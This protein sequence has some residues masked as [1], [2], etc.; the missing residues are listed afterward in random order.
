[1]NS[2]PLSSTAGC[3]SRP[4]L[5]YASHMQVNAMCAIPGLTA[6]LK[7]H[8]SSCMEKNQ[9]G[10][11][12]SDPWRNH[13]GMGSTLN[14]THDSVE[15]SHSLLSRILD[16]FYTGVLESSRTLCRDFEQHSVCVCVF[17]GTYHKR[18]VLTRKLNQFPN[19]SEK[20]VDMT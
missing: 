12:K 2:L 10:Y 6:A 18:K 13:T 1:M 20:V 5:E 9:P 17:R 8:S 14:P 15:L 16:C 19:L 3:N 7:F 4:S 11:K